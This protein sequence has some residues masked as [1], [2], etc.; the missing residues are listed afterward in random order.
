MGNFERD[1]IDRSLVLSLVICIHTLPK[2]SKYFSVLI[3][4][5]DPGTQYYAGLFYLLL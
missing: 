2:H 1:C 3:R 4:L 5:M